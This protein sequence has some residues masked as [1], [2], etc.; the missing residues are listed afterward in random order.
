MTAGRYAQSSTLLS[1]GS[2]LLAGG[3]SQAISC[4]KA[5]VGFI[6]T[7]SA[8]TYDE[9]TGTFTA[10]APLPRAIAYETATEMKN[11]RALASG[12]I[13]YNAYCCQVVSTAEFYTPLTLS[14]SPV[15]LN[16]G[17]LQLGLTAHCRR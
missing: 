13:G 16:L 12:G 8:E 2:V 1:D 17:F 14:F 15:G 5:C 11:G 7:W 10:R 3:Q 4:G 9:A 6:P